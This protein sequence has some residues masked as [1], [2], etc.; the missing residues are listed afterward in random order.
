LNNIALTGRVRERF[1]R[2][3]AKIA[4]PRWRVS[5]W[6]RGGNCENIHA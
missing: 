5:E 4:C 3:D 6:G 2:G 1:C